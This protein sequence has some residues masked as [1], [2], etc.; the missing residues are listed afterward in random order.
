M[1]ILKFIGIGILTLLIVS[2][3]LIYWYVVKDG[4]DKYPRPGFDVNTIPKF[5][6]I[7]LDYKT[8][9][10]SAKSLPIVGS[11]AFDIDNDN[12]DELF[13]GNGVGSE[14]G[15]F[16]FILNKFENVTE[17]INFKKPDLNESIYGIASLDLDNNG[18]V[19]LLISGKDAVYLYLNEMGK[20]SNPINLNLIFNDRSQPA[21]I[22]YTDLN[23]D[24]HADLFISTYL[25][26][27]QMEG[28]TI[29]NKPNYG[30]TSE[31]FLNNGDKT[32]K[33]IT[34][35]AGLDYIHN[36]FTAAFV[37]INNDTLVD[38]VVAYDTGEPRIYRNIG[39]L[40]FELVQTPLTGKYSYPM[41]IAVGDYDNNGFQD[42]MFSN[43]GKTLPAAFL[44]GDLNRSQKLVTDWILLSNQGNCQ[45]IDDAIK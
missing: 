8:Y 39:N 12:R 19:D 25:H 45:F 20:F 33:N 11:A 24:G 27:N 13:I 6:K 41:G 10:N 18:F 15:I 17:Q 1:K 36:T 44:R 43:V 22:T 35:E 40:K 14:A 16:K 21:S 29:F 32:F 26:K 7:T 9:Y 38:L 42:F 3:G 37:E 28:Q 34:R 2:A 31:L 4:A 23:Q 5:D 30:S